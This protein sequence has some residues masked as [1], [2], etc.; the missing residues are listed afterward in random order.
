MDALTPDLVELV[1][2]QLGNSDQGWVERVKLSAIKEFN[3]V[4]LPEDS[5]KWKI[6][7]N[8]LENVHFADVESMTDVF[9]LDDMSWQTFADKKSML[10]VITKKPWYRFNP[11]TRKYIWKNGD[12]CFQSLTARREVTPVVL[13]RMHELSQTPRVFMSKR[14][15]GVQHDTPSMM[16][17]IAKSLPHPINQRLHHLSF[18]NVLLEG[19][20]LNL[21]GNALPDSSIQKL[22]LSDQH[23]RDDGFTCI[24]KHGTSLKMLKMEYCTPLSELESLYLEKLLLTTTSLTELKM[25]H[26]KVW[27]EKRV[28]DVPSAVYSLYCCESLRQLRFHCLPEHTTLMSLWLRH[29]CDLEV[30]TDTKNVTDVYAPLMLDKYGFKEPELEEHR[31]TILEHPDLQEVEEELESPDEFE[32]EEEVLQQELPDEH[33]NETK[34]RANSTFAIS[35]RHERYA[36]RNARRNRM[37][38]MDRQC[39]YCKT[40]WPAGSIKLQTFEGLQSLCKCKGRRCDESGHYKRVFG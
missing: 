5:G 19:T 40:V 12:A 35:K 21:L 28:Y 14:R 23:D 33:A 37:I 27:N 15:R 25:L 26:T 38:V 31:R 17:S 9:D 36:L 3:P 2:E 1:L 24:F 11:Y 39:K 32:W 30:S 10:E 8:I 34:S 13:A 22:N 16:A 20:G 7:A 18:K 6:T 4:K 29:L